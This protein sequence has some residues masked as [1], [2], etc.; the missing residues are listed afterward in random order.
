[1]GE[2]V[3]FHLD[4]LTREDNVFREDVWRIMQSSE[5]LARVIFS[6]R[7]Q[8]ARIS[9]IESS[10]AYKNQPDVLGL[11]NARL[12]T[13][14]IRR[15]GAPPTRYLLEEL[16]R[17]GVRRVSFKRLYPDGQRLFDLAL[18]RGYG[19]ESTLLRMNNLFAE[20][21]GLK[22]GFFK[23]RSIVLTPKAVT[24]ANSRKHLL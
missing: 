24:L 20:R 12:N 23:P 17:H 7:G 14:F 13:D 4:K 2:D 6:R 5:V 9:K 19:K 16:V 1:M 15:Y 18:K 3:L 21:T 10:L 8:T 11:R 22:I